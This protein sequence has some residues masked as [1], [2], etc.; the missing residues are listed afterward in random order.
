MTSKRVK[1]ISYIIL[2]DIVCIFVY[3]C[4]VISPLYPGAYFGYNQSIFHIF[5]KMIKAGKTPYVDMTDHKGIYIFM[6]HYLAELIG[7][8]NHLGLYIVGVITLFVCCIYIYKLLYSINKENNCPALISSIIAIIS[9]ISFLVFQNLTSISSNGLNCETFAT[10]GIVISLYYFYNDVKSESYK[11]LHTFLYGIIFSFILLMKSNY[12]IYLAVIAVVIFMHYFRSKEIDQIVRHLIYGIIGI[13][14]G[15]LPGILFS[16][17]KKCLKEMIYYSFTV[18]F[19]YSNAPYLGLDTRIASI[20]YATSVFMPIFIVLLMGMAVSIFI[21]KKANNNFTSSKVYKYFAI[22]MALLML[23]TL[24][25]ARDYYYYLLVLLPFLSIIINEILIYIYKNVSKTKNK[26]VKTIITAAVLIISIASLA[27]INYKYGIEPMIK[28]GQIRLKIARAVK[29][30]F[31]NDI[32]L[33]NKSFFVLG[34]ELYLYEY[35][36]VLPNFKYFCTPV[37]AMKYLEEPYL[38]TVN[39]LENKGASMVVVGIGPTMKE[40]YENTNVKEVLDRNYSS[41]RVYQGRSIL[42]TKR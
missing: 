34:S 32:K 18:N 28:N 9:S 1:I 25:S 23:A 36:D 21:E 10:L 17:Y 40:F 37:I 13:V 3:M 6:I 16:I 4:M 39:Y 7:E 31:D 2:L 38:E 22:M 35:L 15:L 30:N 33:A 19:K 11:L 42:K 14:A 26:I 20:L 41:I 5:G 12:T 27:G 29:S 24:M 8:K